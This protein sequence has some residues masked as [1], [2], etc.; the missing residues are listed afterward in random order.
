MG[1]LKGQSMMIAVSWVLLLWA[2][3]LK[4]RVYYGGTLMNK[5]TLKPFDIAMWALATKIVALSLDV[6]R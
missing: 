5:L 4:C 3:W 1:Y 2:L 6:F